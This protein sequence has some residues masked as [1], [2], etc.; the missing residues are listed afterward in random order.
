MKK[1]VAG[2]R[3]NSRREANSIHIVAADYPDC[4]RACAE[5]RSCVRIVLP[6]RGGGPADWQER[7]GRT[8]LL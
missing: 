8:L 2:F 4:L 6:L 7:D 5:G 1:G 3:C